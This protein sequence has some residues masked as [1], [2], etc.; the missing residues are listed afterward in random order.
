MRKVPATVVTVRAV[1][2]PAHWPT[3]CFGLTVNLTTFLESAVHAM[4]T[5]RQ[6]RI[7]EM[8]VEKVDALYLTKV[9]FIFFI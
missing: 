3:V 8:L 7:L 5:V 9:L 2:S 4:T 6:V 1:Q